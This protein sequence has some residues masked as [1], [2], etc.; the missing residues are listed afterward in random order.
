MGN[1]RNISVN[2]PFTNNET[3]RPVRTAK[4]HMKAVGTFKAPEM[5]TGFCRVG[6]YIDSCRKNG[7]TAF[8]SIRV[9]TS[10]ERPEFIKKM[11]E[12]A[13]QSAT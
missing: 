5:A 7:I 4:I 1:S 12:A 2:V 3:E 8:Q 9:L 10:G 6:G 11:L 13:S